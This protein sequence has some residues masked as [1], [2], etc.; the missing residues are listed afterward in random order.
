VTWS[1][2][3]WLGQR[4]SSANVVGWPQM[5]LI[6]RQGAVTL[7]LCAP[8]HELPSSSFLLQLLAEQEQSVRSKC[9]CQHPRVLLSRRRAHPGVSFV[10]L[11]L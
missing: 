7:D 10:P 2:A 4:G 8:F 3:L 1:L 5:D 11:V 9:L 6:E